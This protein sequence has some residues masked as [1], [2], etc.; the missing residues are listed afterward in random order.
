MKKALLGLFLWLAGIVAGMQ[1]AKFSSAIGLMQSDLG[2]DPL[3]GGW[4][5]SS[6]PAFSLC[7]Y[8]F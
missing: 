2:I 8:R 5:L 3:F 1:F 7:E 6:L 4:L